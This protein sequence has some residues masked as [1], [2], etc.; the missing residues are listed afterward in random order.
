MGKVYGQEDMHKLNPP[1]VKQPK[2]N[3]GKAYNND[4]N[5]TGLP[6][7]VEDKEGNTTSKCPLSWN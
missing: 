6:P 1:V 3:L 2:E 5:V 4:L 7:M